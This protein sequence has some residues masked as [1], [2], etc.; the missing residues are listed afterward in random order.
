MKN[1]KRQID[2]DILEIQAEY[3]SIDSKLNE[4][5]Y[6][7]NFWILQKLYSVDENT[8]PNYILEDSDRG[9]DCYFFNEDSKTLYLIQNKYYSEGTSVSQ[10]TITDQFLSRS[11]EHLKQGNYKRSLDLQEIFTKY[12]NDEDFNVFLHFYVTNEFSQYAK[13]KNVFNQFSDPSL[14]FLVSASFYSLNDIAAKYYEDRNKEKNNFEIEMTTLRKFTRVDLTEE[15]IPNTSIVSSQFM[16]VNIVE[17]YYLVQK[18][19]SENYPLFEENIRGFIGTNSP[20]NAQIIKTLEDPSE[21]NNFIYYNNGITIIADQIDTEKK[22]KV[23]EE[24][25]KEHTVRTNKSLLKNPQIVN[26]CQTVNSIF[27]VL[28]KYS[29]NEKRKS[30][31]KNVYVMVKLLQ[32]PEG[33]DSDSYLKIVEYNNSQN[34]IKLKDFIAAQ[35]IFTNLREDLLQ[36]GFY[37]IT[38]QNHKNDFSNLSVVEKNSLTTKAKSICD[39]IGI[40]V[41]NSVIKIELAKLLQ[42]L[43]AYFEGGYYAYTKKHEVL[44]S[45]SE[46]HKKLLNQLKSLTRKELMSIYLLYIKSEQEKASSDDKLTPIPYYVL[47]IANKIKPDSIIVYDNVNDFTEMFKKTVKITNLYTGMMLENEPQYNKLIKQKMNDEKIKTA[48]TLY[49]MISK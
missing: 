12:R 43:I 15:M 4:T 32:L 22:D 30:D 38:K 34:A 18:A 9:I 2:E 25:G 42:T 37:L 28:S 1:F 3:L 27:H 29:S 44:K 45:G 11:L 7:F 6:A 5:D 14:C 48:I 33:N 36:Y 17:F 35:D 39:P 49:T 8:I 19:Q 24:S 41:T 47:T 23:S 16:P 20:I 31:F 10:A 40:R 46:I 13:I 21:R 26:G